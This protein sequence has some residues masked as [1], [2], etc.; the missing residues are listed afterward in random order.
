MNKNAAH[1]AIAE[2]V[3]DVQKCTTE[4]PRCTTSELLQSKS[5]KLTVRLDWTIVFPIFRQ[6]R[7]DFFR[8][9]TTEEKTFQFK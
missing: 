9:W 2:C 6:A 7:P 3:T 1:E 8:E 4:L 5:E